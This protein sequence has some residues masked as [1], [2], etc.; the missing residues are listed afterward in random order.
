MSEEF[1]VRLKRGMLHVTVGNENWDPTEEE[2]V[3]V[4]ELFLSSATDPIGSVVVTRLGVEAKSHGTPNL[5]VHVVAGSSDWEPNAEDMQ[6]IVDS[7]H[8]ATLE[9]FPASFSLPVVKAER[10]RHALLAMRRQAQERVDDVAKTLPRSAPP[11][12]GR[13]TISDVVSSAA[14]DDLHAWDDAIAGLDEAVA[15]A[16][17]GARG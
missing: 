4:A 17:G 6:R 5:I 1:E 15:A 9:R 8:A 3:Q 10:I 11:L 14:E 16:T 13:A 12:D 7:V 2:M